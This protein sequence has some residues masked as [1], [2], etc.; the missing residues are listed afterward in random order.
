[1][2]KGEFGFNTS[3]TGKLQKIIEDLKMQI[4]E[5]DK[6][7]YYFKNNIRNDQN[8]LIVQRL[9]SSILNVLSEYEQ[10]NRKKKL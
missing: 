4:Q 5:C 6:R 7:I 10:F 8:V 9:K 2:K 3:Y 1:M